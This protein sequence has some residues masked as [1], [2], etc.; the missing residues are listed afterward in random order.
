EVLATIERVAGSDVNLIIVG[1]PG[2]GK[3]W[4]AH[5][6]HR[7][8]ARSGGPFFP[9]DCAAIPPE[10]AE[11]DLFGFETMDLKGVEISPGIFERA[12]KGTVLLNDI[13][14]LP[15]A[16]Q[17]KILRTVEY[18]T[19]RRLESEHETPVDI[20]IITA[21]SEDPEQLVRK[22]A[23]RRELYY[24]IS[25]IVIELPPLR[26]RREDIP[27]LVDE[28]LSVLRSHGTAAGCTF[29]PE[30][31]KICLEYDW[32]GNVRL[33]RNAVEYA[34]VMCGG[35]VVRAEHLP[36]YLHKKAHTTPPGSTS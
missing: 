1:E 10:T 27:L 34:S 35:G 15:A 29:S 32:P 31:L 23:L 14:A 9:V 22:E 19:I 5:M 28:F 17:M 6:I 4:A 25:P 24:S 13:A 3:E 36:P 8:S 16:V 26:K 30:A 12:D 18:R 20:R 2:T 11:K 7:L 21:V 33:L